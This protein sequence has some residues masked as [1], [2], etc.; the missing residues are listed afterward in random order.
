MSKGYGTAKFRV[1]MVAYGITEEK[2]EEIITAIN[3]KAE[4][5]DYEI[6]QVDDEDGTTNTEI[7]CYFSCR[8]SWSHSDAY[9]SQS[10][11]NWLP[12]EDDFECDVDEETI[13][14]DV[15]ALFSKNDVDIDISI[16]SS[17]EDD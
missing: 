1:E 9:F 17:Y 12:P 10:F 16:T 6:N 5:D 3:S 2:A 7:V 4:L 13:K 8:Y 11:G 15:L 14:S